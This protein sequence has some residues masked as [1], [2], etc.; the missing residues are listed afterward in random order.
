M[1]LRAT[2]YTDAPT[3]HGLVDNLTQVQTALHSWYDDMH[4]VNVHAP[5]SS[6]LPPRAG[7]GSGAF[8]PAEWIRSIREFTPMSPTWCLSTASMSTR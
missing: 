6:N 4:V 7:R 2:V 8:S 5:N 3:D 1:K